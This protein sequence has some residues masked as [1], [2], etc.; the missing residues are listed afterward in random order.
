MSGYVNLFGESVPEPGDEPEPDG[1]CLFPAPC[2]C[3]ECREG[4][5]A[6]GDYD[7]EPDECEP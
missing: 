7:D 1:P 6:D 3:L 4:D 5:Y 2:D